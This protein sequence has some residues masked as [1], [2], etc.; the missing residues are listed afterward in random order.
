MQ[1]AIDS[2][3]DRGD[4]ILGRE[5]T[6]FEDEFG[7][8]CGA[9]HC[10]GVGCGLDA[11]TLILKEMDIGPGDEVI[12]VANTFIATALAVQHV[13]AMPVVV[14]C[15]PETYNMDPGRIRDAITSRTKAIIPVHL[16]GQPAQ[17]DAIC[18]IA[19][20]AGLKV[21][22]DACQA[23]GATFH[24]RRTGV[25]GDAAAFSFYPGKNLGGIGD[26]GAIV[27]NDSALADRLRASRNYG[28]VRKYHH[29]TR[30][31]NTRLDSV[32]AAVLRVKLRQLDR[33]NDR[34]REIADRYRERLADANVVLPLEQPGGRHV[35]HLF[36]VRCDDRD[37]VAEAMKKQG[38]ETGIHYP[39]AIHEQ[40]AFRT[41][42]RAC[43]GLRH[44]ELAC[45]EILSLPICPFTT[46]DEVDE[47]SQCLH[48]VVESC[49]PAL[50]LEACS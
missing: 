46:D 39:V 2:V 16:Y 9:K 34:R 4:F 48:R 36:V 13:G 18:S 6:A 11:L 1:S 42:G 21:I 47:V 50:L 26:G 20:E 30:G 29:P 17:M 31:F 27:T 32:Q 3:L 44:S 10:I 19:R 8:Y 45:K 41:M 12:T 24:G 14:D 22:E 43:G 28:S 15:D 7:A 40:P 23:H 25:L 33:W 5:V 38:I 49:N 35:H 37:V